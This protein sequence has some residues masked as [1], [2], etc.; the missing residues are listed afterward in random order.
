MDDQQ[1]PTVEH[2]ELYSAF[3]NYLTGRRIWE[4]IDTCTCKTESFCCTPET[5]TALSINNKKDNSNQ[6]ELKL[7]KKRQLQ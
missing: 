2:R 3:Y 5:K 7:N 1:G 4:R 6:L